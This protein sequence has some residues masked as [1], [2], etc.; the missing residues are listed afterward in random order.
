MGDD[1]ILSKDLILEVDRK[2]LE[3]ALNSARLWIVVQ[4]KREDDDT[5]GILKRGMLPFG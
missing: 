2:E 5:T 1:E 3:D 4:A